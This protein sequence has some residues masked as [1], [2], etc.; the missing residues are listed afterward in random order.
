MAE[1]QCLREGDGGQGSGR[2][3]QAVVVEAGCV[4]ADRQEHRWELEMEGLVGG[5]VAQTPL[6]L[7]GRSSHP[8]E[9]ALD[10]ERLREPEREAG[11]GWA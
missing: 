11:L 7:S 5:R 9:K 3:S 2:L 6:W 1:K 10:V 4:L 8:E